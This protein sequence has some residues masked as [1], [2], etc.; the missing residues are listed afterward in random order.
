MGSREILRGSKGAIVID[1][2][3]LPVVFVRWLTQWDVGLVESL[4]EAV[5]SPF[6][7]AARVGVVISDVTEVGAPPSEV[8]RAILDQREQQRERFERWVCL[9][10]IVTDKHSMRGVLAAV[11]WLAPWVRM[12]S[13]PTLDLA[14]ER[15]RQALA[16]RHIHLPP[17]RAEDFEE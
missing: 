16:K 5:L 8:R 14:L 12:T 15:A 10:V 4:V 7:A 6:E 2:R 9:D 17:L 1:S 3:H 13:A 11:Q